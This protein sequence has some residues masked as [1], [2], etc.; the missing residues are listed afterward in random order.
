MMEL[1]NIQNI[2]NSSKKLKFNEAKELYIKYFNETNL[3]LKQKY[4]DELIFNTLHVVDNYI[5]RN[6]LMI[7][8]NSKSDYE[9][10]FSAFVEVWI[11][12]LKEG[13]LLNVSAYSFIF[14][15]TFMNDV[16]K[17]VMGESINFFNIYNLKTKSVAK[18]F[19]K[20]FNL[21]NKNI[22]LLNEKGF[23]N[24]YLRRLTLIFDGI[25]ENLNIDKKEDITLTM[26]RI[27]DI[28]ELLFNVGLFERLDNNIQADDQINK[29]VDNITLDEFMNDVDKLIKND[30]NRDILYTRYG[31]KDRSKMVSLARRY[32]VTRQEINRRKLYTLNKLKKAKSLEKY[33]R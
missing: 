8:C 28:I 29:L 10:L 6:D 7:L 5:Q 12:R 2:I 18:L 13:I 25:Y 26:H 17:S 21:K 16:F 3:E 20:Y 23:D 14:N 27:E 4:M 11:K 33:K 9:D 22:E 1:D 32:N 30:K 19:Y 15:S 24:P 31:I